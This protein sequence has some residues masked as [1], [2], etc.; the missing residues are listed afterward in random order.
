M[1]RNMGDIS[2]NT[3]STLCQG[4]SWWI[5]SYIQVL[6][7][8]QVLTVE[9][10]EWIAGR[11]IFRLALPDSA[12]TG[13]LAA[14]YHA[15]KA[16][17]SNLDF[18]R[19]QPHGAWNSRYTCSG[20]YRHS[21]SGGAA[22]QVPTDDLEATQAHPD[23]NWRELDWIEAR[24]SVVALRPQLFEEGSLQS[25]P[26]SRRSNQAAATDTTLYYEI[27]GAV[28][29]L[30]SEVENN[31]LRMGQEA[32]TNAIRHANADEIRVELVYESNQFCCV[33]DN[34]QG[35]GVG[36]YLYLRFGLLGI[37][38]RQSAS[39]HNWQLRVN[40]TGTEIIV[41]VDREASRWAKP[42]PGF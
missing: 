39:T 32:L 14:R 9:Y 6:K 16:S 36:E 40:L 28:Y 25:A 30:P 34:G 11:E 38:E 23:P 17:R 31:L 5:L 18:R 3:A 21:G 24:R 19:T 20:V 33:K 37:S 26:S 29:S 10:S 41:T 15:A 35:F 2:E 12:R 8:Q 22:K 13:Y 4:T 7:T 27:E 42:R 1:E